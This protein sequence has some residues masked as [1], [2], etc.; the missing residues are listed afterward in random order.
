[1]PI[2]RQ[3]KPIEII[4]VPLDLGANRRGASLGPAAIRMAGLKPQLESMGF[5]VVDRGDIAVPVRETL[6]PQDRD[7][8]YRKII[9]QICS[10]LQKAVEK[11]LD[12]D[13]F[14]MTLGGDHSLAIG[15]IN[16]VS[17]HFHQK[18]QKIG[19]IWFDAHADINN[20]QTSPTGNLHGMPM[21]HLLGAGYPELTQL[22]GEQSKISADNMVLVGLRALDP[23]E[24]Q[25][26]RSSG[27]HSYTMRTIDEIG[28]QQVIKEAIQFASEGT[29]GI[30]IS[31]DLDGLD[32]YHTPGV[33]TPVAGGLSYR[34]ARL[35]LEMLADTQRIVGLEFTELNPIQDQ[36]LRSAN[37]AI[38]LIQS[39]L[40]KSIM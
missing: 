9:H 40:G 39:A 20:P 28:I 38:E 3:Q 37:V 12:S 19:L 36:G 6:S 21:A 4:G 7:Q 25:I 10:D 32:P 31:F 30:Y 24:G 1:M 16:G 26:C 18:Q 34:E 17:Q 35:A 14:P 15:S 23:K 8:N 11:V 13:R 2:A 27:I 5:E 22:N 33:S 29:D